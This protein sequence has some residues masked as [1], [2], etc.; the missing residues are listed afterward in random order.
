MKHFIINKFVDMIPLG[1]SLNTFTF[2]LM[3]ASFQISC[4]SNI[5]N[6][7]CFIG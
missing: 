5:E 1:K 2:M 4:Y 6:A 7:I 3:I